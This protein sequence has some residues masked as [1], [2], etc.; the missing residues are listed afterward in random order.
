MKTSARGTRSFAPVVVG[1]LAIVVCAMGIAFL[2]FALINTM[3]GPSWKDNANQLVHTVSQEESGTAWDDG[4]SPLWLADTRGIELPEGCISSDEALAEAASI[5]ESAFEAT[6]LSR[7]YAILRTDYH[8]DPRYF[9]ALGDLFWDVTMETSEGLV[10]AWIDAYTGEDVR[11]DITRTDYLAPDFWTFFDEWAE[12][13]SSSEPSGRWGT[14]ADE[15]ES[16][17]AEEEPQS[18]YA[19][20]SRERNVIQRE[21]VAKLAAQ[22]ASVPFAEEAVRIVNERALGHG[23]EAVSSMVCMDGN[24]AYIVDVELS[25]GAHLF[26]HLSQ[27]DSNSM[28]VYER[29]RASLIDLLYP[30]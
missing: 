26:V 30:L 29:H 2:A 21:Y 22:P 1:V 15:Q 6:P 4:A 16:A 19:A 9:D 3:Q 7:A 25:D 28:I 18:A 12:S 17:A 20:S 8:V 23:A 5:A 11:A 14:I 27:D 24:G 13:G 10:N